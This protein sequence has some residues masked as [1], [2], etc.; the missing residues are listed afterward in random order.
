MKIAVF[1]RFS[2]LATAK[3]VVSPSLNFSTRLDLI[4]QKG[5]KNGIKNFVNRQNLH[6]F[7]QLAENKGL[8]KL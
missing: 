4:P 1:G 3:L 6:E 5:V 8:K 2:A 7:P